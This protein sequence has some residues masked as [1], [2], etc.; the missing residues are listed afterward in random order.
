LKASTK[1]SSQYCLRE[2]KVSVDGASELI[3]KREEFY[4][5]A[6]A[7]NAIWT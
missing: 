1:A 4:R 5:S 7:L 3:D 6:G 2:C